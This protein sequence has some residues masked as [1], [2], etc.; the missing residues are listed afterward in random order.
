MN[1]T[2]ALL[3]A[4]L[5]LVTGC[6]DASGP[7]LLNGTL[8]FSHAGVVSGAFNASGS[9]L[10]ADPENS[11]WAVAA[12]D[13]SI[14]DILISARIP[15]GGGTSDEIFM[16]FPQ[17]DAGTVTIALG[18]VIVVSFGEGTSATWT[19]NLTVGR[20]V[21][22]SVANDRARGTFSG[23]GGCTETGGATGDLTVTGGEFD[24]PLLNF[25][26]LP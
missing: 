1:T 20:I 21:V 23:S 16:V 10:V 22:T 3:A 9:A 14:G 4:S 2:R 17:L 25:S 5:A 11:E 15:R 7:G 8:S 24:V 19:C 13:E 12:R 26:D 18:S 6:D